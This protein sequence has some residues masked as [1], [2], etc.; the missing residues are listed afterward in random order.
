[1]L[2]AS[3]SYTENCYSIWSVYVQLWESVQLRLTWEQ[4]SPEPSVPNGYPKSGSRG[5][6][7]RDLQS[8]GH[9]RRKQRPASLELRCRKQ[10]PK[11]YAYKKSQLPLPI[12]EM[13]SIQ[14]DTCECMKQSYMEVNHLF[15]QLSIVY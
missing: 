5:L 15:L 7:L 4:T 2:L 1:M 13:N 10:L 11:V 14:L 8:N 12:P 6:G 3:S 9:L